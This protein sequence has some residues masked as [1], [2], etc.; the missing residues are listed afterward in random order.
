MELVR[1]AHIYALA[2]K[3]KIKGLKLLIYEKFSRACEWNWAT[4]AFYEATRIVFSTTPDSNKG[5][6]SV[7]VVVFTSYQG[8]ID[9]LEIKAF[10]EG[11]NGL[12]DTVLR[13]INT[14]EIEKVEQSLW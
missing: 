4:Q 3:Y 10:M 14:Y 2:D 11:A 1:Y 9:Q 6:R 7:I 8:L 13:T 12:A 5:P